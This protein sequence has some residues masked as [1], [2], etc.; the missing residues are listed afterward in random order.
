MLLPFTS[1]GATK[2]SAQVGA[3]KESNKTEMIKER[4][5]D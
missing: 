2:S 5:Y 4:K 3:V 1:A